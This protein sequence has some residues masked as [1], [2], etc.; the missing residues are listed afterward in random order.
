M[1]VESSST[2][3][4]ELKTQVNF[5]VLALCVI[6]TMYKAVLIKLRMG[7][8]LKAMLLPEDLNIYKPPNTSVHRVHLS[9]PR[10]RH[11]QR[12]CS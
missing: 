6:E 4:P 10:R 2:Y 12:G 1:H 8:K 7:M 3:S 5:A 9:M 11:R